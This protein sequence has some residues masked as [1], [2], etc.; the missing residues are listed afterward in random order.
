CPSLALHSSPAHPQ[1]HAF[2]TRRSS[3][4]GAV[5]V[6]IESE[7]AVHAVEY[8]RDARESHLE[9]ARKIGF[10]LGVAEVKGIVGVADE[11]RQDAERSEEHTSELQSRVDLVC[12]LLLET[13]K[14]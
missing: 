8:R 6:R 4:L 2:P 3:D 9:V 13:K 7:S 12:R 10:V 11:V 14:K 1:L 5:E